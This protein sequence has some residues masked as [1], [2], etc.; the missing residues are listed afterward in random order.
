MG[1]R[2]DEH[3]IVGIPVLEAG[4]RVGQADALIEQRQPVR[5]D[6]ITAVGNLDGQPIAGARGG[7]RQMS[8]RKS[9]V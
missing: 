2:A 6:A 5:R 9:V 1:V 4:S 7:D 3:V 8:D